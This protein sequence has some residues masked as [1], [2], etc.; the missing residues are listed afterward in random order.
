MA[1]LPIAASATVSVIDS[2]RP[3]RSAI[4]PNSQPPNGLAKKPTAKTTSVLSTSETASSLWKNWEA[5]NGVSVEEAAQAN[6]SIALP[7][8]IPKIVCARLWVAE[9]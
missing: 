3:F 5:K 8:P 4:Q 2:F 7:E 9:V 1:R 6:H